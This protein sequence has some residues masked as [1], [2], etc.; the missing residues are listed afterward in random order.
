MIEELQLDW[1][2]FMEYPPESRRVIVE[3]LR[4]MTSGISLLRH[5][6]EPIDIYMYRMLVEFESNQE[7]P[8]SD[9]E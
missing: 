4:E 8:V 5:I 7:K 3:A 2:A 1:H 6:K 9:T